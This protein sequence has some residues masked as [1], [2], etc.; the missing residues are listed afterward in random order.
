MNKMITHYLFTP[1]NNEFQDDDLVCYCFEYTKKNSI[2]DFENQGCSEILERIT[3]GKK[4]RGC[5]CEV[6]N[7]RGK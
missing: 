2:E 5:N 6:K 4:N 1:D 7:P 3:T